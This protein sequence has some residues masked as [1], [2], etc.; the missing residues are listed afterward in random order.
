VESEKDKRSL[1]EEQKSTGQV[2]ADMNVIMRM[3]ING[4]IDRS[5]YEALKRI[6]VAEKLDKMTKVMRTCIDEDSKD[7]WH[8]VGKTML[9]QIVNQSNQ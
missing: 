4:F 9:E 7:E 8:E 1:D 2:I 6:V 5:E 3:F